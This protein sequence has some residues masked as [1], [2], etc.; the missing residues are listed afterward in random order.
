LDSAE[1]EATADSCDSGSHMRKKFGPILAWAVTIA[2]LIY[3]FRTIHLAQVGEAIRAAYWWAIPANA[4]LIIAVYLADSFA[5]MKTFGWFVAPLSYRE[6]LVVRGATY[7]LALVNY[8]IG[9]GAIVYFVNRSRGVPILRGTAAVLLVM[10]IN[11]L[12]LLVLA[13][14]GLFAAADV[15]PVL[16]LVVVTAYAGLAVYIVLVAVRPRWLANRPIFDVLLSAG[17]GGHLRSMAVRMPHILTLLALS[18]VSLAAFGVVVP[19][20]K[21][22]LCLPIVY[23]VAVLPISF[24]GLGTSQAMLIHFFSEYAPGSTDEARWA[25][26]LAASLVSQAIAFVI[27]VS[28]GLG[29]MR[30]QLARGLG[31]QA[32]TTALKEPT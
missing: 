30:S 21:A 28:I 32:G 26:V 2:I 17:V 8:T 3:L 27:Q 5:I 13:S 9:Q 1:A 4:V 20:G 6:V 19:I 15:P 11:V 16:R 14:V 23:F 24:Q 29:C 31:Q 22:V 18:W 25:S 12:M 7:L 10:G